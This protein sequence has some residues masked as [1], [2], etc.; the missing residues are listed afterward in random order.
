MAIYTLDN[1]FTLYFLL[2]LLFFIAFD[3]EYVNQRPSYAIRY[4]IAAAIPIRTIT[5]K[6]R[7]GDS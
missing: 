7:N 3:C 5:M 1:I 6:Q 2:F 4:Y